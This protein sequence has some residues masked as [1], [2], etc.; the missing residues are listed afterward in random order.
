MNTQ[1]PSKATAG[2]L[3]ADLDASPTFAAQYGGTW[4][5][6]TDAE[7]FPTFEPAT[8]KILGYV[9]DLSRRHLDMAYDAAIT[10]QPAWAAIAPVER[11]RLVMELSQ[12]VL[13]HADTLATIDAR[14]NGS[15]WTEMHADVVKGA[16]SLSYMAGLALELKGE[17]IPVGHRRLNYTTLEPWGVVARIIAFNHPM[18]FACARLAP[19][20]VAGN[21][22]ILK[23]SELT[24]ISALALAELCDGL[25]PPGVVSVLTGRGGLGAAIAEH[26]EIRR[27]SF[28]GSIRTALKVSEGAARSGSIKTLTFELGGK[29]PI[30][31]FPD[32][33]LD[34]AADAVVR[35]MN[36]RRVQGQSCG[37]TSRLFAHAS[38][39]DD[40]LARVCDRI[41]DI[42]I[43]LPTDRGAEM[44]SLISR[45]SQQRCLALVERAIA[46]GA[47][48][49]AGGTPP[50]NDELATG[51]FMLPTVLDNV[52]DNSELAQHEVFGPVLAVHEWTDVD[53]VVRRAN[54]VRYGLTAAVWCND[55][56]TAL[57]VASRLEAGYVWVNDIESRY[58]AVP[59]GGWKDSGSGLEHGIEELYSFTRTRAINI[60]L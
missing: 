23:P 53:D 32:V 4:Q 14:D 6:P 46:D 27:V 12:R 49:V 25:I 48:L 35:G 43:G 19:A 39:K 2:P 42:T 16:R 59:F 60:A 54:D 34:R 10:A 47:R 3:S 28:T 24:P 56:S 33:D 7:L 8:G 45:D 57:D 1:T 50:F 52:D 22:V 30:I 31:V 51:A 58:P 36:F 37:S 55:A 18:L 40:L 13:D 15:P 26:P 29:N 11:G 9:P 44:G 5:Q 21:A 17:T 41:A 20:L 38:I